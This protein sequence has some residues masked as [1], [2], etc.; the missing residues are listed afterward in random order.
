MESFDKLVWDYKK[1]KNSQLSKNKII[2]TKSNL[3]SDN[4]L[5]EKKILCKK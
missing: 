3:K 5:N 2:N 1:K 4:L